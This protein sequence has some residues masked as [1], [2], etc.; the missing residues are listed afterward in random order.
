MYPVMKDENCFPLL[1]VLLRG[2]KGA[3]QE[4]QIQKPLREGLQVKKYHSCR[5]GWDVMQV[6][7]QRK[8]GQCK[9]LSRKDLQLI[10]NSVGIPERD[11]WGVTPA[12]VHIG[13]SDV[14]RYK[15]LW[16]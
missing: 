3:S 6:M 9:M 2:R 5:K 13:G 15:E 14:T 12:R 4:A 11:K 8:R 1:S 7:Q 16:R 10:G